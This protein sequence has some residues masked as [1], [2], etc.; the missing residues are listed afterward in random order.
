MAKGFLSTT[1]LS[2]QTP[3]G[4]KQRFRGKSVAIGHP[5]PFISQSSVEA[6]VH[7]PHIK[8]MAA[9]LRRSQP[10][11]DLH[12]VFGD[13]M[14]AMAIA[15]AN[16]VDVHQREPREVRYLDIVRRYR[17]D[18]IDLFPQILGE[19]VQA[20][21]AG[22]GDVLGA[23]FH[24]LELHSKARGQYFTPYTLSRFMAQAV[25]GDPENMKEII[26][27]H[28][29]VTAMEPACGAGSMVI[30]LAEAMRDIGHNYQRHLHVTAIDIDPRAIHM[31][32]VQLSLLHIPAHL[33]VGNALSGE[34]CDHW[35]TPAHILGGWDARLA[36]RRCHEPLAATAP[37]VTKTPGPPIP[38]RDAV[39]PLREARA[40]QRSMPRQLSV[41]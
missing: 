8:A 11:H 40:S 5:A 15:M 12:A 21:E 30:A 31:A 29:F 37:H 9:L 32:Y 18:V 20:L 28:G 14:E 23:L 19:L 26:A 3:I 17:P 25:V 10:R 33:M 4:R 36:V 13:C 7:Q 1:S 22:P 39:P 35:F 41:F 2:A 38:A 6:C 24:D 27:Q 34:I 16:S